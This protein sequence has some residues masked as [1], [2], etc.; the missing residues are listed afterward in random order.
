MSISHGS[1]AQYVKHEQKM[2][3]LSDTEC[4][5]ILSKL[6]FKLGV[7]PKLIATRLLSDE[8]KEDMRNGEVPIE[9]LE[10]HIELWMKAGM[11]DYAH[12]NDKPLKGY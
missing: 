9:S 12:G 10:L 6:G 3:T 7:S 2:N 8:D 4:K 5:K 1:H 11:P